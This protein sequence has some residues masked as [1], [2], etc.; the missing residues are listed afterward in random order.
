MATQNHGEAHQVLVYRPQSP[1]FCRYRIDKATQV[2]VDSMAAWPAGIMKRAV[3]LGK[4]NFFI[5]GEATG[6]NTLGA[7]YPRVR[8]G[9]V[10]GIP[11]L[12][13]L[14]QRT[15]TTPDQRQDFGTVLNFTT[16]DDKYSL[17]R[18]RSTVLIL[19]LS[20]IPSTVPSKDSSDWTVTFKSGTISLSTSSMPRTPYSSRTTSSTLSPVKST[21][22]ICTACLTSI[23]PGGMDWSM[24]HRGALLERSSRVYHSLAHLWLVF[25]LVECSVEN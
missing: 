21:R 22:G 10:L 17:Q 20:T 4:N 6:G 11:Y 12:T 15:R 8:K 2:T 23:S 3:D 7:L 16:N 5:D 1:R 13:H 18:L 19:L 14:L 24:G 9:R 25:P